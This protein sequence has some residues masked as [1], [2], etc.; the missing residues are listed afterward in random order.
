M[1]LRRIVGTHLTLSGNAYFRNIN[2]YSYNTDFNSD[3][4]E[5]SVYQPTAADQAALQAA[6]YTGYPTSGANSSN[7]PFPYWRCIAQALQGAEAAEKCDAFLTRSWTNQ[8][9]YGV[10]AQA[11]CSSGSGEHQNRFTAGFAVDRSSIDYKQSQQF[12]YINPDRTMTGISA[13]ADG[14]TNVNDVPFDTR[15]D[16]RGTPATGSVFLADTLTAGKFSLLAS[17]RYNHKEQRR[18]HYQ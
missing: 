10:A 5:E 8:N 15:V 17:G 6:G 14:S 3:S 18:K 11:A 13:W 2:S 9:N 12:G 1:T 16:L 4:L 7:T